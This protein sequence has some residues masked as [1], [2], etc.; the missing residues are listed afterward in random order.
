VT[1]RANEPG[2]A[3]GSVEPAELLRMVDAA[4]RLVPQKRPVPSPFEEGMTHEVGIAVTVQEQRR[5][6]TNARLRLRSGI[7]GS[8]G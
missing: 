2:R 7:P 3:R 4:R 5:Q 1:P 8:S 6:A